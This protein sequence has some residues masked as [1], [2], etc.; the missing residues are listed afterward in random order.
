MMPNETPTATPEDTRKP[1]QVIE[2]FALTGKDEYVP[3]AWA[4]ISANMRTMEQTAADLK[5]FSPPT[6]SE[7]YAFIKENPNGNE[8]L[9][10]ISERLDSLKKDIAKLE[11]KAVETAKEE[12]TPESLPEEDLK[13]MRESFDKVRVATRGQ[14]DSVQ[15][16][17][18]TM[19]DNGIRPELAPVGK[20]FTELKL[21]Q[22]RTGAATGSVSGVSDSQKVREWAKTNW[23]GEVPARGRIPAPLQA[24]YDK[25]QAVTTE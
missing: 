13:K 24:A 2:D 9:K 14:L 6:L 5:R 16:Y 20:A 17:I 23:P 12:L 25:A 4:F 18:D 3:A 7:V 11:A 15:T 21:P 8:T 1:E 22:F 10:L 19:V